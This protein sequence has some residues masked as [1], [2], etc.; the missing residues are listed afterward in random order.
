MYAWITVLGFFFIFLTTTLGAGFV[1]IFKKEPS[2]KWNCAVLGF[3]S[4]VMLSASVWS[5][6]LPAVEQSGEN[7]G[8][9]AFIPVVVGF[10]V[11]GAFLLFFDKIL[12]FTAKKRGTIQNEAQKGALNLFFAVSLHNIPEGL[13]VGFAFGTARAIGTWSAYISALSVAIGI[14]LQNLPEGTAVALPLRSVLRSKNKA[15]LLGAVSG[16]V[17]PIFAFLGYFLARQIS[18]L[19]PWLLAFSAGAMVFVTC[20]ELIP[21]AVDKEEQF[22]NGA[23]ACMVGFAVMMALDLAFG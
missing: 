11:G 12:R 13:A 18:F 22:P 16:I 4:G 20:N 19:Q 1:Y 9:F 17:E 6:L 10:F 23:M 2:K 8:K 15:F 3:A 21:V 7:W 14:G 5:L